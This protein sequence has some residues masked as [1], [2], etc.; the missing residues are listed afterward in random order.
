MLNSKSNLF[1]NGFPRVP[2]L[3]NNRS[4][5]SGL[6]LDMSSLCSSLEMYFGLKSYSPEEIF[7]IDRKGM[8][9]FVYIGVLCVPSVIKRES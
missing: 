4:S 2:I 3:Q 7:A 6:H 9:L 1:I 8:P 5:T